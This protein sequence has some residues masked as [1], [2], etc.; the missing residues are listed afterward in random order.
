MRIDALS[1][2]M[3][4]ITSASRRIDVA[5][6]NL[7]NIQTEG[8]VPLRSRQSSVAEAG[9]E[10]DISRVEQPAQPDIASEIIGM[11]VAALQARAS[12]RVIETELERIGTLLD[13]KA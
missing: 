6:H 10:V 8:F 7:A 4:G 13:I 2:A 1:V 9:S 5:S 3:T 12:M 11:S